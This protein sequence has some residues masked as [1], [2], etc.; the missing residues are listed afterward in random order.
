MNTE[1]ITNKLVMI[2]TKQSTKSSYDD[3][4]HDIMSLMM[5]LMG[6]EALEELF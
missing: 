2:M 5:D 3:L 4:Y 6:E 1:E